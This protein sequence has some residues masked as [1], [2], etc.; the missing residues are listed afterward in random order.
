MHREQFSNRIP[1]RA[2]DRNMTF[3]DIPVE[4]APMR[5]RRRCP[6]P[7]EEGAYRRTASRGRTRAIRRANRAGADARP[8]P[9]AIRAKKGYSPGLPR[10]PRERHR[11][12]A[13]RAAGRDRNMTKHDI[14]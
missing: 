7:V 5:A 9:P 8:R 13:E 14:S 4:W 12:E 3:H 6:A 1:D 11:T 10:I 2:E